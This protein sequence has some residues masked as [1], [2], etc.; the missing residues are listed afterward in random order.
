[1]RQYLHTMY[2]FE[3]RKAFKIQL[4]ADGQL[5]QNVL[6]FI[7]RYLEVNIMIINLPSSETSPSSTV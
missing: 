2:Q 3:N 4:N 6:E 7:S 1:M 5:E